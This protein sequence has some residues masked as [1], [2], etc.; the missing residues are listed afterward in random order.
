MIKLQASLAFFI[1]FSIGA[2]LWVW[3]MPTWADAVYYN[4]S[5]FDA[6]EF[7]SCDGDDL[8][9]ESGGYAYN[10]NESYFAQGA[11]VYVTLTAVGSGTGYTRGW[12]NVTSG[13]SEPFSAPGVSDL[14]IVFPTGN[15]MY[16]IIV[17]SNGSFVG[18]TSDICV[19]DSPGECF[20]SP[21]AGDFDA[22]H[23]IR[24]EAFQSISFVLTASFFL[25]IT[26]SLTA[27]VINR[28][29]KK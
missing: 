15:S 8:V 7:Y 18:T 3:P 4:C 29:W 6:G 13:A 9:L 19:S 1:G 17:H 22:N 25:W 12:G 16:G 10:N 11:T 2:L 28:V 14:E 27:W 26:I 24:F 5:D 21:F 23:T 20:P